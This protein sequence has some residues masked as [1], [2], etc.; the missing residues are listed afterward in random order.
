MQGDTILRIAPAAGDA[1]GQRFIAFDYP[2]VPFHLPG[3]VKVGLVQG[4]FVNDG[5]KTRLQNV[6]VDDQKPWPI[7]DA[8]A[9]YIHAT[10]SDGQKAVC[11]NA[12]LAVHD[13][14]VYIF[15]AECD[16][17]FEPNARAT[18]LGMVASVQWLKK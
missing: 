5:L 7:P 18:M 4:G 2:D 13:D 17:A 14:R 6:N 9:R 12:V 16:P 15:D 8:K 11:V 3:M 1:G 10:A